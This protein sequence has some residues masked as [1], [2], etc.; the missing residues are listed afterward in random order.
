MALNTDSLYRPLKTIKADLL[1]VIDE[2][3]ALNSTAIS[4]GGAIGTK[5]PVS[6]NSLI[7]KVEGILSSGTPD[8]VEGILEFLD[9]IPM[10]EIREKSAEERAAAGDSLSRTKPGSAQQIDMTP[11]TQ[12]GPRSAIMGRP[13]SAMGG[14]QS[15]NMNESQSLE[16][17]YADNFKKKPTK[18]YEDTDFS[19]DAI[20]NRDDLDLDPIDLG[21]ETGGAGFLTDIENAYIED[22]E[23]TD[24]TRIDEPL[25]D[26][27]MVSDNVDSEGQIADE[28][29]GQSDWMKAL[30]ASDPIS[31][32]SLDK[33]AENIR[34]TGGVRSSL[35]GVQSAKGIDVSEFHVE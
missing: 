9:N 23:F 15:A 13:Q 6:V 10:G 35:K 14:P 1:K 4:F 19:W 17:F 16:D 26:Y 11:R 21:D 31:F 18:M 7:E 28:S 5:L 24:D 20:L 8:S 33:L 22:P 3:D 25:N 12:N 34:E 30:E 32:G 29:L 27:S 2:L